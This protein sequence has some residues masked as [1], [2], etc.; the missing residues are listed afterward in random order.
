MHFSIILG[1]VIFQAQVILFSVMMTLW[2]SPFLETG[3]KHHPKQYGT[4][5]MCQ[6]E[7]HT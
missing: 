7:V 3:F 4:G 2:N 6:P 1:W 5:G